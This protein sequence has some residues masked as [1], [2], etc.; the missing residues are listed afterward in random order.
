MIDIPLE[1]ELR[2]AGAIDKASGDDFL[3]AGSSG[4]WPG[5]GGREKDPSLSVVRER[6]FEEGPV[7]G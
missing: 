3:E 7:H 5:P 6:S 2:R 1:H 4:R